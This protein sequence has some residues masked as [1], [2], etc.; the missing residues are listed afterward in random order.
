MY[1]T[2]RIGTSIRRHDFW[3]C[4]VNRRKLL[5]VTGCRWI[6][7]IKHNQCLFTQRVRKYTHLEIENLLVYNGHYFRVQGSTSGIHHW[8]IFHPKKEKRKRHVTV[9]NYRELKQRRIKRRVASRDT[10]KHKL[11]VDERGYLIIKGSVSKGIFE[12]STSTGS[13]D[14]CLDAI[15][16]VLLSFFTLLETT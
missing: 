12:R 9:I 16:F 14:S 8:Q 7:S 2:R 15:K 3:G 4:L 1:T 10:R 6:P 5:V 11:P 13:E